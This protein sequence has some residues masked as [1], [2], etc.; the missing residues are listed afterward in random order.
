[1]RSFRKLT[2]WQRAH[3]LALTVYRLTDEFPGTERFELAAQMRRSAVSVPSNIA[4]GAGRGGQRDYARFLKIAAG[5]VS[6]L[7][8]QLLLSKDLGYIPPKIHGELS[9]EVS[10]IRRML[11]SLISKVL[12]PRPED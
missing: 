4:E 8:Y 10:E 9:A 12:N 11:A 5:S 6:E 1:M 3:E 7:D 2:V